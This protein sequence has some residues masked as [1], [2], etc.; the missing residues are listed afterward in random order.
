M[1]KL[2]LALKDDMPGEASVDESGALH[3]IIVRGI[4]RAGILRR[5][6]TE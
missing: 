5:K 3:N 1:Y 2:M 6:K 4:G